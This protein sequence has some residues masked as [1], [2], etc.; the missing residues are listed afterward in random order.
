M[1]RTAWQLALGALI[2]HLLL[3]Q[4]N[5]PA[6][7]TWGAL[8][9]FPLELP[10]ILLGL[11]ALPS[12][13]WSQA[14]RGALV[15]VLMLIATLKM[16][17]FAMFTALG[18]GFNPV[19]DLSLIEAGLR[20]ATGA[21]G[22]ILTVLAAVAA[23]VGRHGSRL[24]PVVGE[25]GLDAGRAPVSPGRWGS[26]LVDAVRKRCDSR[27]RPC[28]GPLGPTPIATGRRLHRTRRGGTHRDGPRDAGR[29]ARLRACGG[30]RPFRR[31]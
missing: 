18:R 7:M 25:R 10:V 22:P 1:S 6:A 23:L 26:R 14:V 4:P 13:R 29:S 8:F 20:L 9:V 19:A 5:H 11:V 12:A 21:I 30:E 3:I 27:D 15:A 28:H 31:S 24:G 17:D 2:F 16:A